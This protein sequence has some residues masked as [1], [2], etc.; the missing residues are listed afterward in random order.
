MRSW[1]KMVP[2]E[3]NQH[4]FLFSQPA[5]RM[6]NEETIDSAIIS[7]GNCSTLSIPYH[8]PPSSF[9]FSAYIKLFLFL[10]RDTDVT[11]YSPLLL[12]Y[13]A[14]IARIPLESFFLDPVTPM[15]DTT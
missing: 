1:T 15:R 8:V 4:A 12:S 10:C 9:L 5:S 13:F 3:M 2:K 7:T 14:K 11:R 6:V